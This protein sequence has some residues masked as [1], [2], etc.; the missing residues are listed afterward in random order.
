MEKETLKSAIEAIINGTFKRLDEAY[1]HKEDDK[2]KT[3]Q[4]VN[5]RLIF[6][7]LADHRKND[8]RVSEQ[9][10]RFAFVE[11]FNDYCD[12]KGLNLFYSIETPTRNRYNFTG[13][14]PVIEVEDG[15]GESASID[16][17]IHDDT[18]KRVALIEF[19]ALNADKQAHDKDFF[20]LNHEEDKTVCRYFIE[21]LKTSDSG[22][23]DNLL[24]KV[25]GKGDVEFVCYDLTNNK[26]LYI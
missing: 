20:E 15:K 13:V 26:R 24:D 22:T 21:L 3:Y 12:K 8:V 4:K 7:E 2:A 19:K 1:G 6:P 5:T 18:T 14:D 10:L 9:E 11:E 23:I 16:L 17:V 25:K